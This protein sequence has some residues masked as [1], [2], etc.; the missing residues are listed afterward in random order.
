MAER[1]DAERQKKPEL[2]AAGRPLRMYRSAAIRYLSGFTAKRCK[3]EAAD[4]NRN[5]PVMPLHSPYRYF[6]SK[7]T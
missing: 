6:G 4:A 3:R 7:N 2:P 1:A 5:G